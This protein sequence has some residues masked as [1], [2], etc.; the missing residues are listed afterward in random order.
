MA[1][2]ISSCRRSMSVGQEDGTGFAS[3]PFFPRRA[4]RFPR[5]GAQPLEPVLIRRITFEEIEH[6]V[7]QLLGGRKQQTVVAVTDA[8]G[9]TRA[10]VE[11]QDRDAGAEQVGD[12][13]R[14]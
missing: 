2:R 12:L 9:E 5:P 10:V 3:P 1:W 14:N 8:L 13:H 11:R 4:S 7:R 6:D